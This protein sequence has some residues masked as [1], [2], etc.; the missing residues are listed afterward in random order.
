MSFEMLYHSPRI[1]S[2]KDHLIKM[3]RIILV[4]YLIGK[5]SLVTYKICEECFIVSKLS[6]RLYGWMKLSSGADQ[7]DKKRVR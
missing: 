6:L 2:S 1:A 3:N 5:S 4:S 7:A